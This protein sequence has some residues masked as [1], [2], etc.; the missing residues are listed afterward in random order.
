MSDVADQLCVS[1][2]PLFEC[3][4]MRATWIAGLRN[5]YAKLTELFVGMGLTKC[6][7][8]DLQGFAFFDSLAVGRDVNIRLLEISTSVCLKRGATSSHSPLVNG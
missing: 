5:P 6:D 2:R 1:D 3:Y 7:E 4:I 8:S